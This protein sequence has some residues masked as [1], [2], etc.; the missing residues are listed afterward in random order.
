MKLI[1]AITLI[2]LGI[3]S[4]CGP[5]AEQQ[6]AREK[7]RID[8]AVKAT[9]MEEKRKSDFQQMTKDSISMAEKETTSLESA[10]I[11]AKGD[12]EVERV[13]LDKIKEFHF[14]RTSAEKE[15]QIR[16]Q[17]AII[18]NAEKRI[19]KLEGQISKL[20]EEI[21]RLKS[22]LNNYK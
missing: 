15:S 1:S 9:Q 2:F 20:S 16:E 12:L 17:V 21:N 8:S 6:A 4:S 18:D 11:G 13:K 7:Q 5:N 3:L 22:S 19:E 14:G 10:L